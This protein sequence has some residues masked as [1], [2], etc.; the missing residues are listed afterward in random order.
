[1]SSP[2]GPEPEVCLPEIQNGDPV[3]SKSY[4][5]ALLLSSLALVLSLIWALWQ[6][7]V[8]LRPWRGYQKDFAAAYEKFLKQEIPKQ[9]TAEEAIRASQ[10]Y[11]RLD[12]AVKDAEA[13]AKDRIAEIDRQSGAMQDRLDALSPEFINARGE[14]TA[15]VYRLEIA[16][17]P[18]AR[19]SQEEDLQKFKKGPFRA[20]LPGLDGT[21]K[22]ESFTYEQLES[23]FDS[24]KAQRARLIT[25]RAELV[26]AAADARKERDT[27]FQDRLNGLTASQ[28]EGLLAAARSLRV[29]IRQT[30]VA[31][32]GLVD[33][34]QSCHVAMDPQLVPPSLRLTK[35]SLGLGESSDA[36]FATHPPGDLLR[37]HDPAKFGCSPCHGG[38]GR[39]TNS[40]VKGHGRHKY[41]LWPLYY[42]ENVEAG[43]QTCHAGDMY[44]EFA[45]ALNHGR[46]LFR[47]KGCIGCHRY[48][49]FDNEGEQLLSA[50]QTIRQMEMQKKEMEME[51]ARLSNQAKDPSIDN[52]TARRLLAKAGEIPVRISRLEAQAEQLDARA[53]GLM[54]EEKKVGPSLKEVRMKLRKE[55]IHYWLE[56]THEFRPETK[57]PQFRFARGEPQAIAAFIWQMGVPGPPPPRQPAG[58]VARGKELFETR[59]CLACHSIGEGNRKIGGTFAANLSRVGEKVN[60]D[61]LV[62]WIHNPRERTR[63]YDPVAKKDLGPEDY[64]RHGKPFVFG[65]ENSRSPDGKHELQ[66]Q[67]Q[68]VMPSL[69]LSLEDARDVASYLMT[70]KRAGFEFPP[71][72]F[73]DDPQLVESGRK[74]VKNYG[75]AGCHEIA[76]LEEEG[77]VGTELTVEGSKPIER[78]DF[79]LLTEHAKRGILPDGKPS[80]RDGRQGVAWYDHKGFFEQKL[81]QTNIFDQGRYTSQLKMPQPALN[82]E[83]ID[84]LTT[85]LLGS[86]DPLMPAE[87]R[88]L[89]AG[90]RRDVQEG[91][92]LITKYNCM[93][94]HQIAVGQQSVLQTLPAYQAENKFKLPPPLLSQGARVDPNWLARFLANPALSTAQTNRNGVRDY[95]DVRMPTFSLSE[96]EIRKLVRFFD[97]MSSQAQPYLPKKLEP[98]TDQERAAARA[99]FTHPAAPCLKCHA[100]G[101]PAHDANA[102]APNFLLAKER[103]RPAWTARWMVEPAKIAPGTAMP[104]GLFR[105]EGGRWVFNGPLP[106][107][108][109]NY[110]GDHVDLLVRYMFQMTPEEQRMLLGRSPSAALPREG[111]ANGSGN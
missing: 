63:P 69:R 1:M 72:P 98:L 5:G 53:R 2:R 55:F 102:S 14:Y 54:R 24:L 74:L 11:Q 26:K 92:W 110:S 34:C 104:S 27:Y 68:T 17:S 70:Q 28:M 105:R 19:K 3:T 84:A 33:R 41:W 21:F 81:A 10:E 108:L 39:A 57:M 23:E 73:V 107:A 90:Q 61:Y 42:R 62:R 91:W 37:I 100:T 50:R 86:V 4:S 30:N 103:L 12:Q 77:R 45:P 8:G 38:N 58:N 64:A 6:E 56:H 51:A 20:R 87:F 85:F 47:Q 48:E 32:A 97:A 7:F 36:P 101:Q 88:Y 52:D 66:V 25:E 31:R 60:Y 76:T 89:P 78:L 29:Q 80:V 106:P 111:A 40:V 95:L 46:E 9:R 13:A 71:T 49:G 16:S 99:L 44:T 35:A 75:C 93:G 43:C 96:N 82:K 18:S 15:M 22:D 65:L 94:C 59:G 79:A 83:E 109:Q 67:Q